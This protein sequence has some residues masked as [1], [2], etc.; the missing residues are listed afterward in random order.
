M[1]FIRDNIRR[2]AVWVLL[3]IAV[4]LIIF[5]YSDAWNMGRSI[6]KWWDEQGLSSYGIYRILFLVPVIMSG[7]LFNWKGSLIA[8]VVSLA[9]MLPRVFLISDVPLGAGIETGVVFLIGCLISASYAV[10]EKSQKYCIDL[11]AAKEELEKSE[12]QYRLIFEN[13]RDSIIIHT[14]DGK[15]LDVNKATEIITGYSKEELMKMNAA[16]FVTGEKSFATATRVRDSLLNN[17][18]I[19]QPYEQHITRKDGTEVDMQIATSLI[20]DKGKPYAFQHIGRDVTEQRRLDE[21]LKFYI[22]QATRAQEEERKRIALEL[23]DDTIQSLIVLSRQ[24]D[25]LTSVKEGISDEVR[26]KLEDLWQ[27]TDSILQGLRR[28]SQDL[29][30]AMLDRLGLLPSIEWL[31][32]NAR[33][34]SGID[35]R[36]EIIGEEHR[37][38]EEVAVNLF[39]ITQEAISNIRKHSGATR[40]DITVEFEKDLARVTISDNGS[41][42]EVPEK[43]GDLAKHGKL[44]LAGMQ[45]RARLIGGSLTVKSEIGVGTTIIIEAPG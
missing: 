18:S 10:L 30:P 26:E 14:I 1:S 45:E 31:A 28:L 21:N 3:A 42:F 24:L 44:G 38:P 20:Y 22:L 8:C 43:T 37:L 33:E 9:A 12:K 2:P 4:L 35:T 7:W 15:V 6:I 25:A 19:E 29:R 11:E 34:Y 16:D 40:A 41:G 27:Q 39:R 17:V 13:A 32:E 5:H 36:V 23:H